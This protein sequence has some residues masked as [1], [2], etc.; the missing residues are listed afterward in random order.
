MASVASLS[1]LSQNVFSA[2]RLFASVTPRPSQNIEPQANGNSSANLPTNGTLD[3]RFKLRSASFRNVE[4]HQAASSGITI[5]TKEGDRV[6]ISASS[7]QDLS[8]STYD[9][10]GKVDSKKVST[11]ATNLS[12]SAS[13][14]LNISVEGD[15]N[16]QEL[17]DIEQAIK[18]AGNALGELLAGDVEGATKDT[19]ELGKLSTI[20]QLDA[21]FKVQT[22]VEVQQGSIQRPR[23]RHHHDEAHEQRS[24]IDGENSPRRNGPPPSPLVFLDAQA[25]SFSS[26]ALQ[27]SVTQQTS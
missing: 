11:S 25:T 19:Q 5:V 22:Q 6:T 8:Y 16:A 17:Q 1:A 7:A 4:A 12:I 26:A 2:T 3:S 20:A 13:N 10:K 24:Q 9:A 27:I 23:H 18:G 15:L 14:S 21:S